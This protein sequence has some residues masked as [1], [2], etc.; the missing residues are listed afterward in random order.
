MNECYVCRSGMSMEVWCMV[1]DLPCTC[2]RPGAHH[3]WKHPHMALGAMFPLCPGFS[4]ASLSSTDLT[5]LVALEE[6]LR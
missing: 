3:S 1:R 2:G 4:L 5:E 6:T